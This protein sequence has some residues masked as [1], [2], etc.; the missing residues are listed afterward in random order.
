MTPIE[1]RYDLRLVTL[2][3]LAMDAIESLALE[4][5][6]NPEQLTAEYLFLIT[7]KL[8]SQGE[9]S[10]MNKMIDHYPI[11]DEVID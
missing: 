10:Y 5:N 9:E 11:L 8:H 7:K 6:T 1:S 3:A 4:F 2:L